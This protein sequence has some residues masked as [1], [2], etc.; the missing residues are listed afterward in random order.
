VLVQR[1]R[2]HTA[3]LL[4]EQVQA[5][6]AAPLCSAPLRAVSPALIRSD[7]QP[8]R[9]ECW[10]VDGIKSMYLHEIVISDGN[11]VHHQNTFRP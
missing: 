7:Y 6:I 4:G 8:W 3:G 11:R 1:P 2:E 10:K 5:I 9:I